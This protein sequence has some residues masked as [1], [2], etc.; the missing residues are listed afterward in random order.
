MSLSDLSQPSLEEL[1]VV[2]KAARSFVMASNKHVGGGLSSADFLVTL[3]FGGVANLVSDPVVAPTHDKVVFSKGHAC[4]S[5][6]F[7]LWLL[8]RLGPIELGDLLK[9]GELGSDLSRMPRRDPARGFEM[10][11]GALGQGLS[12]GNGLAAADRKFGRESHTFVVLGDAECTEGQVWEAAATATALDLRNI[13]V[14]V[15]AN[16]F[17]SGIEVP[18]EVWRPRWLSFGWEAT[19]VDGHDIE[20]TRQ[21]IASARKG[22][23]TAL[24]LHTIKGRGLDPSIEGSN[25]CGNQV[26][27]SLRPPFDLDLDVKAAQSV[28]EAL[29]RLHSGHRSE[30]CDR[31]PAVYR[32]SA[33]ELLSS[34]PVGE[35]SV[36]KQF[37]GEVFDATRGDTRMMFVSP[38]AIRNSGLASALHEC[39][40]WTWENRGSCVLQLRIA[41]QDAA[42]LV[43]GLAAGGAVPILVL[44]EGF[45]WRMLDSIR[46][47]IAYQQLPVVV[48]GTSGGL[49]DPLGPMV[50]SDG[51]LAAIAAIVG[52]DV[53]EA[54]DANQAKHLLRIALEQGRPTYLRVPHEAME[55]MDSLDDLAMRTVRAGCWT[56]V[57]EPKPDF[58]MLTAGSLTPVACQAIEQLRRDQGLRGRLIQVFSFR[59]L[60]EATP[61]EM[62]WLLPRTLPAVSLH[63]APATVLG[64]YLGRSDR[65][66]GL[67]DFGV[68]GAPVSALYREKGL[69]CESVV[70][71]VAALL[72]G[73]VTDP[74]PSTVG[75]ADADDERLEN[76]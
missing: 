62:D 57:D 60:A 33:L 40:D 15:D 27:A 41:E 20:A 34:T 61:A 36:T 69:D 22:G 3:F 6:Y 45:V 17:G 11:S 2:A 48:V 73:G 66:I 54:A 26:D 1:E 19:D 65:S 38:D 56:L 70:S 59:A 50:Q 12:F 28:V 10:S 76:A 4:G 32:P 67:R 55:V 29:P 58:V 53:Y 37:L 21:A 75:H 72:R 49:S 64:Q 8:G 5:L 23:R 74:S 13:T 24:I 16:G 51:C 44:M 71:A 68:A 31:Q 39:G 14:L 7:C 9:F 46:Q 30:P 63:N 52:L 18:R 35:M 25:G 47:T 42:S 43:A